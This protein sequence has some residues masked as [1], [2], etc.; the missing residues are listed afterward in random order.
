M[1]SRIGMPSVGLFRCDASG[2]LLSRPPGSFSQA[3]TPH[4]LLPQCATRIF[5]TP[6]ATRQSPVGSA[7]KAAVTLVACRTTDRNSADFVKFLGQ[8]NIGQNLCLRW[9]SEW[10]QNA[11][12]GVFS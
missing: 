4:R 8:C 5:A 10:G 2:L 11:A 6:S 12:L 9:W 7:A 3:T 1:S